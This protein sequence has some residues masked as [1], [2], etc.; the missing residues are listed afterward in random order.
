[1]KPLTYLTLAVLG[2]ALGAVGY[3]AGKS[4]NEPSATP[5]Q[6]EQTQVEQTQVDPTIQ[7]PPISNNNTQTP[8]KRAIT[9]EALAKAENVLATVSH[10]KGDYSLVAVM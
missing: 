10:P 9:P 5:N 7:P 1:M 8:E 4:G 2:I 3:F 6:V